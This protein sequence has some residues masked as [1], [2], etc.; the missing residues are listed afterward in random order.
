[1]PRSGKRL[2]L[3]GEVRFGDLLTV[4]TIL[5][6]LI[7][8]L[9]SWHWDRGLMQRREAYEIRQASAVTLANLTR[10]RELSLSIFEAAQ[11]AYIEASAATLS[12]S[13]ERITGAEAARDILWRRLLEAH[14]EI[15]SQIVKENL[16]NGYVD[17]L[18][19]YPEIRGRYSTVI[20][21]AQRQRES[22]LQQVLVESQDALLDAEDGN[23]RTA[24]VGNALRERAV[25]TQANYMRR[26]AVLFAPVERF[27]IEKIDSPDAALLREA[28]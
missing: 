24:E 19:Y 27:C 3:N 7:S 2:S 6:S 9:L 10:W 22:M 15:T 4:V 25:A 14:N 16:N 5:I 21:T 28:P 8:V 20:A 1:M 12:G 13:R 23:L 18:K 26:F 11:P 17:L